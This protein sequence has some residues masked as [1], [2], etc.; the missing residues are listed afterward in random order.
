VNIDFFLYSMDKQMN[1]LKHAIRVARNLLAE[2]KTGSQLADGLRPVASLLNKEEKDHLASRISNEYFILG[3][4]AHDPNLYKTCQAA[5]VAKDKS[6]APHLKILTYKTPMC[7]SC[8]L[9]RSGHCKLMGGRLVAG[10]NDIPERAI[11]QTAD[12]LVNDSAISEEDARSLAFKKSNPTD[13]LASL[14]HQKIQARSSFDVSQNLRGESGSRIASSILE[15]DTTW[16]IQP[17]GSS[18]FSTKKNAESLGIGPADDPDSSPGYQDSERFASM[19]GSDFDVDMP[20]KFSRTRQAQVSL[21]SSPDF[22]MPQFSGAQVMASPE[23]S[24]QAQKY[25][26]NL[27]KKASQLLAQGRVSTRT[28]SKIYHYMNDLMSLGAVPTERTTAIQRQ[29]NALGG[30]LEL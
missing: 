19:V 7:A 6:E 8:G 24:L 17:K 20:T 10:P 18:S 13:R 1:S 29:L 9:N 15:P 25:L 23:R 12:L 3:H 4:A 28:A 26:F 22:D 27:T 11:H 30:S 2:G 14:H 16:E 5:K 21:E